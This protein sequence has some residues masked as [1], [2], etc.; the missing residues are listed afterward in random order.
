MTSPARKPLRADAL[1]NRERL[2]QV[3]DEVFASRG[4]AV[5]TEEIA[6]AAGVGIGTLFRHFPAK[7][8]LLEAV[9]VRRLAKMAEQARA[10]VAT[11]D[12]GEAL[13]GF[14]A[15]AVSESSVKNALAEALEEAGVNV[16]V[17]GSAVGQEVREALGELLAGA[18]RAGAVRD[19]IGVPELQA[20]LVGASRAAQFAGDG[21]S[22]RART[23]A[24]TLDGLRPRG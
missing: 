18:Q 2:L 10:L 13:F 22:V 20:L 8:D 14:F 6:R 23:L 3:A 17:A 19:D 24:V 12:P 15:L 5:S 7:E 1:R 11:G 9:F 4:T 21:P 16:R